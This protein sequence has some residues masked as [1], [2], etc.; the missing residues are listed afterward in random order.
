MNLLR[1]SPILLLPV[2]LWACNKNSSNEVS[3]SQ[4]KET[5]K[6]LTSIE[7][8]ILNELQQP[9]QG[10]VVA[11]GGKTA[12]TD[13]NGNFLLE[14]IKID[15]N[16]AQVRV[17]KD[18]YLSGIRTLMVNANS[19]HYIQLSLQARVAT[20][21]F[22]AAS[23]GT[24]NLPG[25]QLTLQANSI[26][27]KD[28]T[29][30]TG[31]VDVNFNYANPQSANF[32]DIL[33]G[34]LRG[35]DENKKLKGLQSF[36]MLTLEFTGQNGEVLHLKDKQPASLL[37][38]IPG[39]LKSSAPAQIPL[40]FFNTNSGYWEQQ[41][42]AGKQGGAYITTIKGTGF[43]QLAVPYDVINLNATIIDQNNN[44]V[45]N[46]QVTIVTK[47]DFIPVFGY[48]DAAGRFTGKVPSNSQLILSFT[49]PCGQAFYNKEIGPYS[50]D[51]TASNIPVSL[52]KD[53]TLMID[54][55]ANNCVDQPVMGKINITIDGLSYTTPIN[56]G[57]F[58]MTILRC[59][60]TI[61]DV[62]ISATD[63]ATHINTITTIKANSGTITPSLVVCK[64]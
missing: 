19:V 57:A 37:I 53:S 33:A 50:L 6:V 49:N 4:T 17:T 64:P 8:R 21:T 47:L 1:L 31:I 5:E 12:V 60:N 3:A 38:D 52:S 35:I 26:L 2:L 41:A 59:S 7:G 51:A 56:K 14:Q 25:G 40:W 20:A 24:V 32:A 62:S 34:D 11:G 9:L 45:P 58:K 22:S 42:F 15:A 39:S 54:G 30:Y 36:G 48:T 16:A 18:Q 29:N 27:K 55:I 44:P 23:G 13:A 28:N 10:A 43:W 46:M 63:T 61:A